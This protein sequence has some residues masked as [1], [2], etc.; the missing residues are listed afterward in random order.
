[1]PGCP[2]TCSYGTDTRSFIARH[3]LWR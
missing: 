1:V 2:A 3:P